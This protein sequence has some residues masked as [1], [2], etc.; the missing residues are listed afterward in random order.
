MLG[1]G[2]SWPFAIAVQVAFAVVSALVVGMPAARRV[3]GVLVAILGLG[4]AFCISAEQ[5]G[6]RGAVCVLSILALMRTL[7]LAVDGANWDWKHRV[8]Q[9]LGV[10]DIRELQRRR[11]PE[12]G[13]LGAGSDKL[14][15]LD[16]LVDL[17]LGLGFLSIA[18]VGVIAA[19]FCRQEGWE[20]WWL[21]PVRWLF[22]AAAMYCIPE[23]SQVF[24]RLLYKFVGYD[25]PPLHR[26]PVLSC[27]VREFWGERWNLVVHRWLRRHFFWPFAR[28]RM[29]ALGVVVAFFASGAIHYWFI[30][31]AVDAVTALWMAA[32]FLTQGLIVLVESQLGWSQRESGF[33]ARVWTLGSVLV[34]SPMFVEPALRVFEASSWGMGLRFL[35][36][37]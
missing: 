5:G 1:W 19:V 16:L 36:G 18:V 32:F 15:Y 7:D 17:G 6:V 33:W 25:T 35:L 20:I 37:G 23:C 9:V 2:V 4:W 21:W 30:F 27:S 29:A 34:P 10:V 31:A 22:G 8:W 3:M 26:N 11:P 13:K 12:G 28:R 14:N 24:V